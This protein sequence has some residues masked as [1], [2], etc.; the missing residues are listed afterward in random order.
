MKS[1]FWN[2][3][4][5]TGTFGISAGAAGAIYIAL[6]KAFAEGAL[7]LGRLMVLAAGT[8]V[9]AIILAGILGFGGVFIANK[10][11]AGKGATV[12]W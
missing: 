7:S 9:G 11:K 5:L 4:L 10:L 8:G 1:T 12:A 3:F 6:N 2:L